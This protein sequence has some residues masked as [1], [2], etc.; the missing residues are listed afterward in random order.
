MGQGVG[1]DKM[2]LSNMRHT[3]SRRL[4]VVH[5]DGGSKWHTAEVTPSGTRR[6]WLRVAHGDSGSVWH[7]ATVPFRW[8]TA[9]AGSVGHGAFRWPKF[10]F[11]GTRSPLWS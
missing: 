7:T 5:G 11:W 6:Q 2:N 8:N 4:G 9:K 1:V 10:R 3:A